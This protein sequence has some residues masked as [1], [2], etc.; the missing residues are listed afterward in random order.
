MKDK[1]ADLME[2]AEDVRN[3]KEDYEQGS[4]TGFWSKRNA[5]G[6]IKDKA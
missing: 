1:T 2:L 3:D 6:K 4:Y 5:K